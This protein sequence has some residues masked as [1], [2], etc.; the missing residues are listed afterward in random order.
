MSLV[1]VLLG[2]IAYER[3]TVREY[4]KI[5]EPVV[6]VET[7]YKGASRRDH[8]DPGHPAIEES[9]AGIEGIDYMSSISRAG[10]EPDHPGSGSTR[11]PDA[12]AYDVRDRVGR[13]RGLLPD[14]VD[15]PIIA[16]V[17]A[18]AQPI[19]YLAFS[20]DRHSPIEVTDFADRFVKDRLQNLPGVADVRIFGERATP[21]ASGWTAARLAAYRLTPQDVENA[22]RRQN[23]EMP[24]GRIESATR[25][26]TVV[27]RNRP[28]HAGAV[29]ADHH[30]ARRAAIRCACAT[31]RAPSSAPED[32]RVNVR[33]NGR[34]AVALGIVKQATANPLEI[35]EAVRAELPAIQQEL[36]EGMKHR[37]RLRQRRS[38][39]RTRSR[40]CSTTIG[41]AIVLVVA[42]DLLLPALAA[43]HADP[44]GHHPGRLVGAFALMY[45]FG[46]TINTL[47][48]LA[49]V[50]AIGLVVD[51]AIVM[52]ENIHRHVEEGMPPFQAAL[53]GQHA[54]SALPC[55]R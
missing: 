47:T 20:S 31:W 44:A 40:R 34:N 4:P 38:S 14:E 35:R 2:L 21:C 26:F 22:L 1:V 52:L 11:D 53:S 49:M 39:S 16:K 42:G 28:A 19:I 36:P 33:F 30:R 13:V 15:E 8:R 6:T 3:L 17:E 50:L 55:S 25:E 43:R 18:D 32:E 41:E 27:S 5:D 54:R 29:R 37:Y 45:A 7:T 23:I 46:F 9:L 24:A 51:D 48:L 10:E 12:A